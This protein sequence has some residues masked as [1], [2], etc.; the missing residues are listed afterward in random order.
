MEG[1]EEG[2]SK[3]DFHGY[4]VNA[5]IMKDIRICLPFLA[6]IWTLSSV[7]SVSSELC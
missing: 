5:N 1:T 3:H 6:H 7:S 2:R 4:E